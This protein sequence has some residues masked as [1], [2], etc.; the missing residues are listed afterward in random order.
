MALDGTATREGQSEVFQKLLQ[1]ASELKEGL[2]LDRSR[3]TD[4]DCEFLRKPG[5]SYAFRRLL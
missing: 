4:T 3:N 1:E 2:R 5:H